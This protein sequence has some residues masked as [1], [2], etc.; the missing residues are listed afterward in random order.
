MP[1][2]KRALWPD[3]ARHLVPDPALRSDVLAEVGA[4]LNDQTLSDLFDL[5]SLAEVALTGSIGKRRIYGV[6]DRLI[7]TQDTILAIDYKSNG[8]VPQNPEN[9]PEGLLRQLGAYDEMLRQIYP[10]RR[11]ETALLWTRTCTLMRIDADIVRAALE[12]ATTDSD[13]AP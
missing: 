6:I 5:S 8:I 10:T 9:V 1:L 4:I 12:R 7:V 2:H 11:I 13:P 3:L